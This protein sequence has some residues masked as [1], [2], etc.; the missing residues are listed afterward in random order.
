MY[1][2]RLRLTKEEQ[3]RWTPYSAPK[4]LQKNVLYRTYAGELVMTMTNKEDTENLQISRRSRVFA[5]TASGDTA[6]TEVQIFDSSGEQYTMG[7][8]PLA[9]MLMGTAPDFRSLGVYSSQGT[10]VIL[11]QVGFSIPF[12]YGV[13]SVAPH[14]FEP[15][16]VLDPNQTLTIKGRN[17]RNLVQLPDPPGPTNTNE[18]S[19]VCFNFHVWEFP[20]E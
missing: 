2:P 19:T 9:N 16:I 10:S 15:N 14:V 1:W 3:Q 20:I 5:L 18:T 11:N 17:M 13:D 4:V 8:I 12:V 7:Y 6:N